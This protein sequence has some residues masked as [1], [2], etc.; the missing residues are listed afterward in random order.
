MKIK[1]VPFALSFAIAGFLV[2]GSTGFAAESDENGMGNMMN[3]NMSKMMDAMNSPEGQKMM[4]ACDDV[5]E[6]Y[7]EEEKDN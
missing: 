7:G 3:G 5:M 1:K 2:V 6:S 4:Q